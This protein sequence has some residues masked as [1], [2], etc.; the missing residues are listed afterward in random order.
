RHCNISLQAPTMFTAHVL[1]CPGIL[2][3]VTPK[4]IHTS[5]NHGCKTIQAIRRARKK[6]HRSLGNLSPTNPLP[7]NDGAQ[8]TEGLRDGQSKIATFVKFGRFAV[9]TEEL[10]K[11]AQQPLIAIAFTTL[12][13]PP[14]FVGCASR[15]TAASLTPPIQKF[16]CRLAATP[17]FRLAIV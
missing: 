6:Q 11:S 13:L 3:V 17:C 1:L 14:L 5:A 9:V 10:Q 12:S 16:N 8:I 2:M 4:L 7:T 15:V